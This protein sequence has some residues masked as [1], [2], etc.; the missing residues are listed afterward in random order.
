MIMIR[1][2]LLPRE[3]KPSKEALNWARIF[4]WA[5][6]AAAVVVLV[7]V[8]IHVFRSFEIASLKSDIAEANLEMAKYEEQVQMVRDLTSKRQ[9]IQQRISVIEN[10]DRDRSLRVFILDELAR[11]LPEYVWLEAAE[12]KAGLVVIKGMAFSNLA[13]SQLMDELSAKAHVD[14]VYLRVIK[15]DEIE[16]QPVLA[17]ELGYKTPISAAPRSEAAKS[18]A[19]KAQQSK[20]RAGAK[21]Q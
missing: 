21:S 11:S 13:V 12:E 3:E 18:Q 1:I 7:G 10:L 14:S 8:G 19:G 2:N 17:F 15:R 16:N 5:L 9:A 6:I 4:V 20:P